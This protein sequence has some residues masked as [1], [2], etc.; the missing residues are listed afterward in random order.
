[1]S[2][3]KKTT[4][5]FYNKHIETINPDT[6]YWRMTDP[7]H[8]KDFGAIDNISF[9]PVDTESFAV[10]CSV[11]VQVY[12]AVTK[13]VTKNFSKFQLQAYGGSF[14]KDGRLL[15]AGDE[16]NFVRLFDVSSK[17]MLRLFKGHKAPVHRAYFSTNTNITSFSDDRTV[18]FWDI[19]SERV[20]K[21]YEGHTDYIRAGCVSPVTSNIV[22]SGGYDGVL[23]MYDLRVENPVLQLV[24]GAPVEAIVMHPSGGVFFSAGG[25]E[26]KIWDSL[27]GGKHLISLMHHH[28][29]IT[30]LHLASNGKRLISGSLDKHCKIID[31]TKYQVVHNIDFPNAVLSVAISC[32]DRYLAGGM[33]DGTIAVYRREMADE[34]TS[35]PFIEMKRFAMAE[36]VDEVIK[37]E[38]NDFEARFDKMLRKYEYG[39]ALTIVLRPYIATKTPH[40]TIALIKEL[41]HR[42]GLDRA[43][44][45]RSHTILARFLRF[46]KNNLGD[47]RFTSTLIDAV[48]ITLNVYEDRLHEFGTDLTRLFLDLIAK[49]KEEEMQTYQLLEL[50]GAVQLLLSTTSIE[51]DYETSEVS[52]MFGHIAIEASELAQR[53]SVINVDV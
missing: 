9:N 30:T 20:I 46:I 8:I 45:S 15:V 31:I 53:K 50:K 32:D 26:I 34:D 22:I 6:S 49:M 37:Q 28:K 38:K 39:Q 11:R 25:T 13:L 27:A 5:Q 18:K 12:N 41:I 51:E 48:N 17:S 21:T 14:R 44:L 24:H 47:Y 42:K 1:M 19:P 7:F 16:E 10:T 29:T 3:F 36:M 4:V 43:I 35:K 40:V 33:V 52:R 23:K 2:T